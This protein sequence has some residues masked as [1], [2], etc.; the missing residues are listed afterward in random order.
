MS[1]DQ[2]ERVA[3]AAG[4]KTID[5]LAGD[6]LQSIDPDKVER[7][8]AALFGLPPDAEPTDAQLDA[9]ETES[10][11]D[12]LKPFLD[13]KLRKAIQG[14]WEEVN[15]HWQVIEEV[16]GDK[17]LRAGWDATAAQQAAALVSSLRKHCEEK[18]DG[19]EALQVLYSKPYRA[20]LRFRQVKELAAALKMAKKQPFDP[21]RLWAAFELAEPVKVKGR[22]GKALV[23][24][25]ALVRRAIHPDAD[26]VPVGLTVRERYGR[27]LAERASAGGTFTPD[28]RKWLDAIA[29]HIATSLR[30]E[31]DDFADGDLYRM[32]GLGKAHEVFGD[33]LAAL[34]EELN[35]CLAA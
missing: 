3:T 6:L 5:V 11:R 15:S 21:E 18:R 29:D 25:I 27:W 4:G 7:H 19:V 33:Q 28:Q 30:V 8:A 10:M 2:R 23:D 14:V 13:S 22:G 31:P 17:L 9:A 34:L 1:D 12:A 24:V 20:G 32:G 35:Q 26:L 16:T